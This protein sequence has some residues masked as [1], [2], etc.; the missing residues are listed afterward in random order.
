MRSAATAELAAARVGWPTLAGKDV[1]V[2]CW[3]GLGDTLQF[4]RFLPD[5]AAMCRQVRVA[6]QPELAQLVARIAPMV[7]LAPFGAE[8][9]REVEVEITELG[10]VL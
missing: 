8:P 9:A 5:L 7:S 2:R 1:L 4:S 3:R 6:V 10:H